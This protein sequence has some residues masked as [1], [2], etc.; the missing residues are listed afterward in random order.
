[1]HFF[2]FILF[3]YIDDIVW[4]DKFKIKNLDNLNF[5]GALKMSINIC[6]IKYTLK[7]ITNTGILVSSNTISIRLH[8]H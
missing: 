4:Y 7:I 2:Y 3:V 5:L 6:Q 8:Q 1:M